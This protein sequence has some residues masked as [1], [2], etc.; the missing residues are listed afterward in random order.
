M[1]I[2]STLE[3]NEEGT[4]LVILLSP[5]CLIL[6]FPKGNLEDSNAKMRFIQKDPACQNRSG[7]LCHD[8]DLT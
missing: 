6:L 7:S 4:D 1:N 2:D 8:Q 3:K 5:D